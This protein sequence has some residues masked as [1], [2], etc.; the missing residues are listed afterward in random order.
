MVRE[1][2]LRDASDIG[3]LVFKTCDVVDGFAEFV[4]VQVAVDEIPERDIRRIFLDELGVLR[5]KV[6]VG[7]ASEKLRNRYV[8]GLGQF[9]Y[10][11]DV[12]GTDAFDPSGD[13]SGGYAEDLAEL[14]FRHPGL[15]KI[16]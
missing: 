6:W 15:L 8:H 5:P 16:F 2:S 3:S 7:I 14:C 10:E 12:R 13:G 4:V 9:G 11:L 1:I